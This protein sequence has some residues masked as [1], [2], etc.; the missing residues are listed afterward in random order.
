MLNRLCK[1]HNKSSLAVKKKTLQHGGGG[2]G[3]HLTDLL[4]LSFTYSKIQ[5]APS[6]DVVKKCAFYSNLETKTHVC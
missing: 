5:L 6:H 2:G 3:Q 1:F 4:E